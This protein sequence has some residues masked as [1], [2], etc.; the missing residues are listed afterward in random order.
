MS[1]TEILHELFPAFFG[2]RYDQ[3]FCLSTLRLLRLVAR[4]LRRVEMSTKK[5]PFGM[6]KDESYI[7]ED[8]AQSFALSAAAAP[9]A[10]EGLFPPFRRSGGAA[11]LIIGLRA[12]DG[13]RQPIAF[14]RFG[15]TPVE[16]MRNV[17]WGE[18]ARVVLAG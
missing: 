6:T 1:R 9:R 15:P 4:L 12:K 3:H 18:C 10:S 11:L 17:Y 2:G 13:Y 14:H 5:M 8:L 16:M 7:S